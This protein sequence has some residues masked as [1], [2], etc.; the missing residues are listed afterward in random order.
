MTTSIHERNNRVKSFLIHFIYIFFIISNK[1]NQN[2]K[3]FKIHLILIIGIFIY[4]RNMYSFD[5]K[6]IVTAMVLYT[7]QALN[8][9]NDSECVMNNAINLYMTKSYEGLPVF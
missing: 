6:T 7:E 4:A 1:L 8:S 9:R 5:T 3:K 2:K